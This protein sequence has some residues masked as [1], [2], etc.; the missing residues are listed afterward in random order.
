MRAGETTG[1]APLQQGFSTLAGPLTRPVPRPQPGLVT[2]RERNLGEAL[3]DERFIQDPY[4][5]YARMLATA[6]VHRVAA[7]DFYAVCSRDAV[8]DAVGRPNDFS[9]NLT[10]TMVYRPNGTVGLFPMDGLAGPTQVLATADDPAHAVHRK[11]V[12]PQLAAKRIQALEPFVVDKTQQLWREKPRDGPI[13]WM[14]AMANRLPMMVVC[15]LIGV[16]EYDAEQLA[17]WSYSSTQLLEGL[18]STDQ[19][20]AAGTAAAQLMGYVAERLQHAR[21]NPPENLLGDLAAACAAGVLDATTA[22]LMVVMLFGAGGESTAALIGSATK[23]IATHPEI[24]HRLRAN[25]GIVPA[26]LEE[27]LRFEPPFRGHYRHVRNDCTLA[28]HALQAGSRV[29]LLWGAAN[30]DPAHFLAPN[31]FRV[32]RLDNNRHISFGRGAHFCIGAALARLEARIVLAHLLTHTARIDAVEPARWLPSLLVRRLER[33][34]LS[35]E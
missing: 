21:S 1:S 25:P 9:S 16:P 28:G 26:F 23:I 7:S 4:P 35:T 18:V 13:E 15:R 34:V 30:R 32:G 6:P 10:G 19:L 24:Q 31:E 2:V 20:A 33:L 5:L 3:F 12:I 27:V 11:Q 8:L 22:Q 14:S 17:A 29:I